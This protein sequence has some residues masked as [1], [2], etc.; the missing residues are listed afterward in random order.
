MKRFMSVSVT[1]P[2]RTI[3]RD[4]NIYREIPSLLT[5]QSRTHAVVLSVS[6]RVV[7]VKKGGW[8]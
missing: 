4:R 6:K 7:F 2:K 3:D 5:V 1:F 8:E